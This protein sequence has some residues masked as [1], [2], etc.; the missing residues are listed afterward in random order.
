[1]HQPMTPPT[2]LNSGAA[3]QPLVEPHLSKACYST[4]ERCELHALEENDVQR[5]PFADMKEHHSRACKRM[6]IPPRRCW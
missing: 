6:E 2:H 1:M 3:H 4:K 5:L